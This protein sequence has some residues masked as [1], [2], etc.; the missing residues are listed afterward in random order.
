MILTLYQKK[1]DILF[2]ENIDKIK[3]IEGAINFIKEVKSYGNKIVIVTNCNRIVAESIIKI[4]KIDN[5][6]DGLVIGEECYRS[7]PYPD[8]YI[9]GCKLFDIISNNSFVFE[10]SKPGILS[11]RNINPKCLIGIKTLY[12]DDSLKNLGVNI[13]ID[14]YNTKDLY[15]NIINYEEDINKKIKLYIYNSYRKDIRDIVIFN[16][17]IKGG[18]ISDVIKVVIIF[19]DNTEQN[20]I[21]KLENKNETKLSAMAYKLGLYEREYYFYENISRYVNIE[22]PA[23]YSLIKD[24]ELN[25]IGILLENINKENF[26]LNL[27][28]NIV[29]I[30]VSL[31]IIDSMAKLHSKFWNKNLQS[32][33]NNLLKNNDSRF[34]PI[35]YNYINDNWALFKNRWSKLLTK[36]Q[37]SISEKIVKNFQKIQDDLSSDNLTLC[38]GDV[39]SPNIFYKK[40]ENNVYIPYFIDWQHISYGKG[41]QDIIFLMIESYD[42]DKIDNYVPI[43]KNY[44]YTKLI[45]YNIKDYDIKDYEK[46]FI[47]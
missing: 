14:N 46:D 27:N 10:D 30:D 37:L 22:I 42:I 29:S 33:F 44:Y 20:C 43:F 15:E 11:G 26:E 17:K 47:N 5:L 21:L 40:I 32:V 2:N 36:K 4:I 3:I 23:F 13:C 41:I 18:Y 6:I 25:N 8:P 38:H 19:N 39:K 9:A 7:K 1:K 12:N 28:L 16:E 34:N 35:W 31:K 24:D 45:E